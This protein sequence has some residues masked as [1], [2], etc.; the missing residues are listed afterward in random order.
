MKT[1]VEPQE[2]NH[3]KLL[4]EIDEAEFDRSLDAAF[5]KIA[6]EVNIPG[7]RPGKVPRRIL[8]ARVGS[9]YARQ[10]AIND[11]LP[12]YYVRAL[13]E[14]NVDA[15]SSPELN[16]TSGADSGA[17]VF[18][19]VVEVRPT[20]RVPGYDGLQVTVPSPF[21]SDDEITAQIDRM[22]NAFATLTLVDRQAHPGD[23]VTIDIEGTSEGETIDG[24][25]ASDY[26]YEVGSGSVVPELDEQLVG[27]SAGERLEFNAMV[28]NNEEQRIDFVVSVKA[29]NEKVMP[30]ANDEWAASASEF[31]TLDELRSDIARRMNLVKRVQANMAMRDETVKALVELVDEDAPESLVNQELERRLQDLS[32]RLAQQGADLNM[33]MQATGQTRDDLVEPMRESAI[34]AVKADLA[35]R[36]VAASESIE[37][38]EEEITTEIENLA[39]RFNMKP[40]V[41]RRNLEA[42]FQMPILT[43][44]I[45][46]AKAVTWLT[47]HASVVDADG[48]AVDRALLE[49]N[50]NEFDDA[51][52]SAQKLGLD[53][54]D[55]D[56]HE[57][58][59][60]GH[61]HDHEG[62]NH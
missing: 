21:A 28:P 41:A 6:R 17:V 61:D 12:E 18:E 58:H 62:H 35:L 55:F 33:Y 9:D 22:R 40:K 15:I 32:Q 1:T 48:K 16:L 2:A 52:Q 36:S 30:D 5:K 3:V 10:Q 14:G 7:F 20:I 45:R 53:T 4:V 39:S 25:T 54:A 56:D 34:E 19:A 57:G 60:H 46:K 13:V 50:P 51:E 38:S 8:E 26:V 11:S 37:V 31:S 29:V 27:A 23:S 43:A 59:D 42:N 47:E 44:D 24:L 49:V